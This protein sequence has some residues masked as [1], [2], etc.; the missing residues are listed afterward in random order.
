MNLPR[1]K[2]FISHYGE[3]RREV[4]AFIRTFSSV[5]IPKV[6]GANNNDNFINST[7]TNYVMQRIRELYLQDSTVTIVL[8][9]T[10]THSRRYI[11]WEIKSSLRQGD[12]TPNGLMGIVL[13]SSNNSVFLPDRLK[14]NWNS[15][16]TNCYARYW[17]YPSTSQ[18]LYGWIEDA[19]QARSTRANLIV[20]SNDMMKHN[21]N[22]RICEV[23]H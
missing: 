19:H 10:C 20:N 7:D 12:F 4:D 8:L 3:D 6:L 23:T 2:V 1:R 13:P 17:S 9:G 16:H 11:D 14:N 18:Q 22:C 21:S 5:F 15:D